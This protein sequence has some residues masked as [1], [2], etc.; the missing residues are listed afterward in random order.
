MA[1]GLPSFTKAYHHQPYAAID[2]ASPKLSATGK[3]VLITGGS[4]GVGKSI[5]TAFIQAKAKSVVLIA[6]KASDLERTAKELSSITT[7]GNTAV[8]YYAADVCDP[9]AIAETFKRIRTDIGAVDVFAAAHGYINPPALIADVDMGEW[10][11][12]FEV[13]VKG[14]FICEQAFSRYLLDDS[15]GGPATFIHLTTAGAH[16]PSSAY[17]SGYAASKLAAWRLTGCFCAEQKEK[18]RVFSIHPGF[19]D[20]AMSAT[21]HSPAL[22]DLALPGAFCAWLAATKEADFLCGR[23]VWAAWDVDELLK[24]EKEITEQDLLVM[25]LA[26]LGA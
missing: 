13:N 8:H 7:K 2:P 12:N 4:G 14:T 6:R 3:T 1:F 15:T 11:M 10:W 21:V 19:L 17:L 16:M 22:D 9:A 18:L 24:R 25:K 26:G 20:T 23:L 5:A